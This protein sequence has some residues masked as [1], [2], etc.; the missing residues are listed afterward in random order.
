[1]LVYLSQILGFTLIAFLVSFAVYPL[2]I[3]QLHRWKAGKSIRE[4]TA[5]GEKA[6]IFNQLHAYKAGTPTMG[7]GL[8][9]LIMGLMIGASVILQKL[10]WITN[11]LRNQQETYIILF[12]FFSMGLIGLIDDILNIKQV[13]K[14][15]GLNMRA[16]LIGLFIFSAAISYWFYVRLGIDYINL[17]PIAGKVSLGRGFPILTFFATIVIVNAINIT[18]GL[19]GL[20]GGL[21]I[22]VLSVFLIA[23]LLN[24]TFIAATVISIIIAI[25]GAFL[26]FNIKPA[27]VFMGDSGAFAL[28]GIIA[29][30]LYLLNMRTGIFIPFLVL[31]LLFMIEILSSGLQMGRK[32]VFHKKLFTI[33]PLHHRLEYRGQAEYTIVM[34]LR[35]IQTVLMVIAILGLLIQNALD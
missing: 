29:S 35:L 34:R 21:N 22:S 16:K 10:G 4:D 13:G 18:D 31:F 17:R 30:M 24:G 15:K 14:V 1:M 25:L 20:A 11:S 12:G 6:E 33:A 3:Q 26:F 9:L 19:D 32:K 8:F 5:T 27:K 23:A 28:G 7:G 2:Y